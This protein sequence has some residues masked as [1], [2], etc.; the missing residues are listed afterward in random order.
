MLLGSV[1]GEATPQMCSRPHSSSGPNTTGLPSRRS[2]TVFSSPARKPSTM[3]RL[4]R[5]ST[6]MRPASPSGTQKMVPLEVS[7]MESHAPQAP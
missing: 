2:A 7:K 4:S 3:T 6:S 1:C 5:S